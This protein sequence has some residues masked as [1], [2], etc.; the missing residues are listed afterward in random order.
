MADKIF[1][2]VLGDDFCKACGTS[3]MGNV[4]AKAFRSITRKK[5]VGACPDCGKLVIWEQGESDLGFDCWYVVG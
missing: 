2:A 5:L 4:D 3:V 1:R